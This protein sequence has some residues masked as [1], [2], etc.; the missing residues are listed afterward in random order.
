MA[1]RIFYKHI[2]KYISTTNISSTSPKLYRVHH[3]LV[4][5]RSCF[6]SW[7]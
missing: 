3:R 5:E 1:M 4:Y 2:I 7:W 6:G